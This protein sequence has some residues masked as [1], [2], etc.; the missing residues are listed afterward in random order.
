MPS[1]DPSD[2]TTIS[3]LVGRD[4]PASSAFSS[5]A[6][7]TA[8]SSL[9]AIEQAR[10]SARMPRPTASR[11]GA[12]RSTRQQQRV[13]RRRRR[14]SAATD[15]RTMTRCGANAEGL[16]PSTSDVASSGRRRSRNSGP[17]GISRPPAA[18]RPAS[19]GV[20]QTP[21]TRPI[22]PL[23]DADDRRG[24]DHREVRQPIDTRRRP[25]LVVAA[26]TRPPTQPRSEERP[27][28]PHHRPYSAD[29]SRRPTP[30]AKRPMVQ[31][32]TLC[33]HSDQAEEADPERVEHAGR[34]EHRAPA[35]ADDADAAL[36]LALRMP[37]PVSSQ[38]I[39]LRLV[40]AAPAG[41]DDLQRV[42]EV[43][44][45]VVGQRCHSVRRIA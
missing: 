5:L 3:Q 36:V 26:R 12:V 16:P 24:V 22:V 39:G 32:S 9:A 34:L 18:A 41:R 30:I 10:R 28:R 14:A 13:E 2:A 11:R 19:R 37:P 33:E 6:S 27:L 23:D 35:A 15:P 40:D 4:N 29:E 31:R 42:E 17:T 8:A 43:V 44:D 7:I 25:A 45:G 38:Q 20:D 21:D 1:T